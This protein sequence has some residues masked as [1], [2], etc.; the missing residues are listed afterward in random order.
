[1]RHRFIL[2]LFIL[3]F[4]PVS[5]AAAYDGGP[6]ILPG[7]G[8]ENGP[9][10]CETPP[11]CESADGC[12]ST[13]A[14]SWDVNMVN[15]NLYVQDAPIWY[16][17][18]VG[19]S[20]YCRLSYNSEEA[21]TGN[22]PFGNRWIFRFSAFLEVDASD[23]VTVTMPTGRK[24][25]Y[26]ANLEG[27]YDL[28]YMINTPLVKVAENHFELRL[29]DG[30]SYIFS[31]FSAA[32]Q[33]NYLTEIKDAHGQSLTL[34]Y[35]GDQLTTITD[36][37][38]QNTILQYNGENLVERIDDPFGRSALF[39]YDT[40]R[41][42]TRITDMGG[43]VTQLEYDITGLAALVND[44]GRTE[45]YN[46][47]A[48]PNI[49]AS[50]SYPPPGADMRESHRITVTLP[51][52]SKEE[53]HY[54]GT[55]GQSWYVAP[56]DYVDYIDVDQNNST[57][58]EKTVY[59]F[60][61]T[62]KGIREAISSIS[63]PG[64]EKKLFSI[65]YDTGRIMSVADAAGNGSH[66]TYNDQ[67]KVLTRIRPN[68]QTTSY[69]Y[70]S[71]NVDLLTI[72][73]SLGTITQTY[74]G[75]HQL[76]SRT[77][78]MGRTTTYDYN[79]FGQLV[80]I[81]DPLTIETI[82]TYNTDHRL[83]SVSRATE[84]LSNLTYDT[85]GR[86]H[87]STDATGQTLTYGYDDLNHVTSITYPDSKTVTLE[88]NSPA[89]P[90]L[91]TRMVDRS[92]NA[93][94]MEY[95]GLQQLIKTVNAEGGINRYRY[96]R[97]G[98]LTQF[99]DSN[100][101]ITTFTYDTGNRMTGKIYADDR[102]QTFSY[103]NTGLVSQ[104]TNSRG[105]QS[106][107]Y[108]DEEYNLTSI[109]YSDDT[110]D[111]SFTYDDFNRLTNVTDG[112]GNHIFSYNDNS[113][114]TSLDGPYE[115]DTIN[116]GYDFLGRRISVTP[117]S[118]TP[119][120]YIYDDINRL[121]GVQFDGAEYTYSYPDNRSPLVQSLTR[122]NTSFTEYQ[123]DP[124]NRLTAVINKN[125]AAEIIN[126]YVYSYNDQDVRATEDAT[127]GL[128]STGFQEGLTTFDYN[129]VNQL[130][131]SADPEKLFGYDD[132]GN[133]LNGYTP[134]GFVST[135]EYDAEERLTAIQY[136]DA[137]AVVHRK[138]FS[139]RF[140]GFIGRIQEYA[141]DA[142]V[143]DTRIIRDSKLPLQERD[144]SNSI[145]REFSWG[146]NLGGGIGGLLNLRQG[147]TDYSYLYD[148]KGNVTAVLDGQQAKVAEYGYN[149]FGRLMAKGGSL[150]QPF[151]FSTKRYDKNS[152]LVY[153]G[154][155]F[156]NPAIERWMNRDPLGEDG[157]VN[158]YGFVENDP[159]NLVDPEGLWIAQAI[160]GGIGAVYGMYSAH[161]NGTSMLQGALVGGLTGVLSTIPIP[162]LN[163]VVSGALMGAL[164]GGVGNL[165]GQATDPC[166][167]DVDLGSLGKSML[168]GGVGG[169][170]GGG[171]AGAS[172]RQVTKGP[173][174][175]SVKNRPIFT[176]SG[177]QAVS[178]SA[179][180]MT[181]GGIDAG[182]Q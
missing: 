142:L 168:A 72:T 32:Q 165:A 88:Y 169:A 103:Y 177:Q 36:A 128:E 104:K 167:K 42:L 114:L 76:A 178:A 151:Q 102:L 40:E 171:L 16:N 101:N 59:T 84:T 69:G 107:F 144:G 45:F 173:L 14:P 35:S 133:M 96:D 78:L 157:G 117:Q 113:E 11:C 71:N 65:D 29:L 83:I 23:N 74:N 176:P 125:S 150:E 22:E 92:G 60:A 30:R 97:N 141:N 27:G 67:G 38:G 6:P 135:A 94:T 145:T 181:A 166:A 1:M 124:L 136:T 66:F 70:D 85:I 21:A 143:N 112:L 55:L 8:G 51:D 58:A 82:F 9:P 17:P 79:T 13:G 122:P 131:R 99:I 146:A 126:S 106:N 161:Q 160:G 33:K 86:V 138:E 154:Y 28:P 155:R 18:A 163:G 2:L 20:V 170:L 118:A 54:S 64:G 140:D 34:T 164:S 182:I 116:Y 50:V 137:G 129:E 119:L 123:Y 57:L 130:L 25:Y 48:T 175:N 134:E 53:Y 149:S 43:Y 158:L 7:G 139:Y 172:V 61:N 95:D 98:N 26:P 108:Y 89:G 24:L 93:T 15:L 180:G 110:P 120:I 174:L 121:T 39:A 77:D 31:Y 111:V 37:I 115:N 68:N 80:K 179:G 46:E 19:P 152:G 109:A 56:N 147:G 41:N 73:S 5:H 156:Y 3:L 49:G 62:S 44:S 87:T 91:V 159:V 63:Y 132:D 52:D 12:C 75:F 81:T 4:F 162:G 100:S 127:G 90:H 153:Y 148:G 105:L 47:P 10:C